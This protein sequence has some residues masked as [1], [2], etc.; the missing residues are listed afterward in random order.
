MNA[1]ESFIASL[2]IAAVGWLSI[3]LVGYAAGVYITAP[4]AAK[5]SGIFFVMRFV[6]LFLL[7]T[8][9]ERLR[10]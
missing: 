10:K 4:Q 5:M 3:P 8:M 9:F 1:L 6:W 7:R 2:G